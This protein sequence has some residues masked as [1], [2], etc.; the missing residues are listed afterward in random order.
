M[1]RVDLPQ[2]AGGEVEQSR[3]DQVRELV[4]PDVVRVDGRVVVL[5]AVGDPVLQAG[6]PCLQVLEAL[7]GLQVRVGLGDREQVAKPHAQ[8]ALGL[9]QAALDE[10]AG[11]PGDDLVVGAYQ[12]P[13][14]CAV[15]ERGKGVCWA[16]VERGETIAE[17]A[18]P[19]LGRINYGLPSGT[20]ALQAGSY[21]IYLTEVFRKTV[22]GGPYELDVALG[23]VVYLLAYDDELNSGS[24][25]IEDVSVP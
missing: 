22:V 21:D 5:A 3:D 12:G 25:L 18:F 13:L 4:D 14:A 9:A 10:A 23:D 8:Q 15:L 2:L 1:S 16:C 6:D 19:N 24:I 11:S 17:D 20:A 7:V